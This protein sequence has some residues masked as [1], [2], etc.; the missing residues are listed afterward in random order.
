MQILPNLHLIPG[1]VA[2][3]FLLVDPDGLTLIDA[4]LPGSQGKILQ[5]LK[6]QGFAP[7][8]LKRILITHSDG[9]H[10]GGLAALQHATQATVF[11]SAVEAEAI[12]A[13]RMTRPLKVT[14]LRRVLFSAAQVFFRPAPARVD[15]LLVDGQ[16]LPVLGGLRVV[17]TP[18]HT[19]AHLSFFAPG[20][21]VLFCGDSLRCPE[22]RIEV[23]AGANT[24]D[25]AKAL[26]SARLLASLGVFIVCPGH[27]QV[28]R[29]ASSQFQALL[30]A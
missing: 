12:R 19:P 1:I 25:E 22:G 24:W 7:S 8:A 4:G 5:Y 16:E 14:G 15:E 17:E 10:V 23:S 21:G 27:G 9:D 11:A 18:G 28:V 6:S 26:Q 20:A 2:N 13:G 29:D 3:P 30:S